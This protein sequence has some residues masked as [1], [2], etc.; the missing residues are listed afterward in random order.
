VWGAKKT[1]LVYCSVA[2]IVSDQTEV[3]VA[4]IRDAF[5]A[6]SSSFVHCEIASRYFWATNAM[7]PTVN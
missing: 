1:S 7:I 4:K 6:A 5:A 3:V 2:L